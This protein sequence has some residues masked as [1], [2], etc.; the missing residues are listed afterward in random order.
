MVKAISAFA[1][2]SGF[3]LTIGRTKDSKMPG[4]NAAVIDTTT[5]AGKDTTKAKKQNKFVV[6]YHTMAFQSDQLIGMMASLNAV[7][8]NILACKIADTI[9]NKY[10]LQDMISMIEMHQAL[11]AVL[12]TIDNDP[13]NFLKL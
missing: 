8:P 9:L 2:A 5:T 3:K 6:A 12:M 4:D 1:M 10:I 11:S 13:T 7:W